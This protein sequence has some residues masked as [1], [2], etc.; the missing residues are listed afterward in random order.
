[1][2]TDG[3]AA[4]QARKLRVSRDRWRQRAAQK[5]QQIRQLRVT[6][7]D[8]SISREYWKARAKELEEQLRTLQAT[9]SAGALGVGG[10]FG[11]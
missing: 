6:V 10:F 5:Q 3:N 11:G 8:L 2:S 7:R 9:P 4:R 1:M